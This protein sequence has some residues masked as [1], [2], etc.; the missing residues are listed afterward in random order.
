MQVSPEEKAIL[1]LAITFKARQQTT[2]ANSLDNEDFPK[3]QV[4]V[5]SG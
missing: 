4:E 1:D 5:K 3:D 2:A